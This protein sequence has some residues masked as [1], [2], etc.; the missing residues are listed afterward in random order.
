MHVENWTR[1]VELWPEPA[2]Q[3]DRFT[4]AWT[5]ANR[6]LRGIHSIEQSLEGESVDGDTCDRCEIDV[7][8]VEVLR[9]T[10]R[11]LGRLGMNGTAALLE[12]R[13]LDLQLPDSHEANI[14]HALAQAKNAHARLLD[15]IGFMFPGTMKDRS[16]AC[17]CLVLALMALVLCRESTY[18]V[19]GGR[20]G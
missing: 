4:D 12:E 2:Q 8:L 1:F 20:P 6:A 11:A 10:A 7:A 17:K 5:M 19:G 18:R 9:D 15:S 3:L 16:R 13:A 14:E